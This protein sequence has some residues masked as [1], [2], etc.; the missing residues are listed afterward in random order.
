M[1]FGDVGGINEFLKLFIGFF[2]GGISSITK[3][4]LLTKYLYRYKGRQEE[5][6]IKVPKDLE[7]NYIMSRVF[8]CC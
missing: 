4:S 8:I 2:I 5:R 6:Q 3:I 7:S 1:T